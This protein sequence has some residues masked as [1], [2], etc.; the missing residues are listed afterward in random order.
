MCKDM[1]KT[2]CEGCYVTTDTYMRTNVR[3]IE[4]VVTEEILSYGHRTEQ[5]QI[6]AQKYFHRH[7]I[8]FTSHFQSCMLIV[9]YDQNAKNV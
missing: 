5:S 9:K 8:D 3:L 6:Q 2:M 1:Y 4:S 7:R